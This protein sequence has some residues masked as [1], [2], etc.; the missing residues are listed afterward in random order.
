MKPLQNFIYK[1]IIDLENVEKNNKKVKGE[2][3]GSQ[4]NSN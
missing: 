1:H 2:V 3:M 4:V